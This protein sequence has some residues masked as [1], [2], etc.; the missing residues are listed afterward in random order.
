MQWD[1]PSAFHSLP[2]LGLH[3]EG[4]GFRVWSGL[5]VELLMITIMIVIKACTIRRRIMIVVVKII[6]MIVIITCIVRI[7]TMIIIVIMGAGAAS[8]LV[9]VS[10][11]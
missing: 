7:V 9:P 4:L 11:W 2:F 10:H 3:F 8:I 5:S 6:I 1:F